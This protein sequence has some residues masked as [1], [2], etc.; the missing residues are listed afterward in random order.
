MTEQTPEPRLADLAAQL[1]ANGIKST[2]GQTGF[3]DYETGDEPIP[4]LSIETGDVNWLTVLEDGDVALCGAMGAQSWQ[5]LAIIRAWQ[6]GAE[7]TTACPECKGAGFV[8]SGAT[9]GDATEYVACPEC[10]IA[11][12]TGG[13]GEEQG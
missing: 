12:S 3:G 7:P 11:P 4:L 1:E 9:W 10:A 8:P 6:Q 2:R 13:A 5:A